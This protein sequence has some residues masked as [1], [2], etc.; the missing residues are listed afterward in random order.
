M[1]N[2]NPTTTAKNDIDGIRD[3]AKHLV[4]DAQDKVGEIKDKV[5]SAKDTAVSKGEDLL[6]Q[7]RNFIVDNPFAAVGA[8]FGIGYVFMRIFRR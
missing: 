4:E 6:A 3:S 7:A 8:A 2:Q 1:A 5:L